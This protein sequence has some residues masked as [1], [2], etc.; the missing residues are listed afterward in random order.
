MCSEGHL[1]RI[2]RGQYRVAK[3][4]HW[5]ANAFSTLSNLSLPNA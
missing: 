2:A 4:R 1:V 3:I 5:C